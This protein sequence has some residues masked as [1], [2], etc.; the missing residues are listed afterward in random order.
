VE[1]A[2]VVSLA[3]SVLALAAAVIDLLSRRGKDGE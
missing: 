3:A 1:I 2:D